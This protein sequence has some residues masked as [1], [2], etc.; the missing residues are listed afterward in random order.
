MDRRNFL[1]GVVM[2]G[3]IAGA[4]R[5]GAAMEADINDFDPESVD[6][7]D[8]E[9]GIA[10]PETEQGIASAI[11]DFR[12]QQGRNTLASDGEL[13]QTARAHARDMLQR[14]FFS[15]KNPEGEGP[16]DRARCNAGENI[17]SSPMHPNVRGEGG[18]WDTTETAGQVEATVDGWQ[19]SDGH[20][21]VMLMP[22]WRAVGVGVIHG[23]DDFFAVAM[24]C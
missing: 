12:E 10:A 14:D 7:P 19:T 17:F 13:T 11:N 3:G 4:Y 2:L 23:P 1:A 15:H 21:K 22:R 24:F 5:A 6:A 9:D 8:P 20:R 18:P 16:A